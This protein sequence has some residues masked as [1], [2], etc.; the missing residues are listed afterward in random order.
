MG[1]APKEGD[2]HFSLRA[3]RDGDDPELLRLCVKIFREAGGRW[4]DPPA[5][6]RLEEVFP[7]FRAEIDELLE[8]RSLKPRWGFKGIYVAAMAPLWH[9]LLEAH[10]H[11]KYLVMRRDYGDIAESVKFRAAGALPIHEGKD[12]KFWRSWAVGYYRRIWAFR[13]AMGPDLLEVSFEKLVAEETAEGEL[14]SLAEF[15]ESEY[16]PLL[17]ELVEFRE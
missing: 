10:D 1:L 14:I 16:T 11:V 6:R 7:A 3:K 5:L 17:L 13:R 9:E 8:E 15:L 12:L 4:Y 2:D